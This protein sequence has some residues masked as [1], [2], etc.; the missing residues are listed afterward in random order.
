MVSTYVLEGG[1]DYH[2]I[3]NNE[4]GTYIYQVN[5]W[6]KSPGAGDMHSYRTDTQELRIKTAN[7]LLK[8]E[9]HTGCKQVTFISETQYN[10]QNKSKRWLN[11]PWWKVLVMCDSP[12]N[13]RNDK[14]S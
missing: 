2:K 11:G 1:L 4:D 8:S 14:Y 3:K 6:E 7:I 13:P 10:E 9:H 12:T 5:I